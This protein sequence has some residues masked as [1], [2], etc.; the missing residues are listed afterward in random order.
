MMLHENQDLGFYLVFSGKGKVEF[1]GRNYSNQ[2]AIRRRYGK[3]RGSTIS[4]MAKEGW[5]ENKDFGGRLGV[6]DHA[7]I[8]STAG[9]AIAETLT[10][11]D[12]ISIPLTINTADVLKA[13]RKRHQPPAW[14][15][16]EELRIGT[17]WSGGLW[18]FDGTA[19]SAE[20]RIDAW[21]IHCWK[22]KKYRRVAYEVK[23]YRSDWLKELKNP[24]KRRAAMAISNYFY[25]AAPE[26][27]IKPEEVPDGCGLVE[28]R[29]D[30][31]HVTTI[32]AKWR[33]TVKPTWPFIASLARS[34]IKE[35]GNDTS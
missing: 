32:R 1:A 6:L 35:A 8:L 19:I 3:P 24:R 17:G 20:Q 29:S 10:T 33:E 22:S 13:L 25:F 5:L 15:F 18:D 7:W 16:V 9:R 11:D 31:L 14:V 2:R 26:G 30:Q 23:V 4:R 21:A 28:V 27:L 12:L 34:L